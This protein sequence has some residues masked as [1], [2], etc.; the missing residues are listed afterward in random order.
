[1]AVAY[2]GGVPLP[3]IAGASHEEMESFQTNDVQDGPS[4]REILTAS[5]PAAFSVSWVLT[6]TEMDTFDTWWRDTTI[7]GA[8][9]FDMDLYVGNALRTHELQFQAPPRKTL[10]GKIWRVTARLT[11]IDLNYG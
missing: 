6:A 5:P 7:R 1:M 11:A 10:L 2:P 8:L 3:L 4:R 9:N